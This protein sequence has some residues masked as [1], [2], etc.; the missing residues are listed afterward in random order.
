MRE[1]LRSIQ[2]SY[3]SYASVL[4]VMAAI[5][6]WGHR[7]HWTFLAGHEHAA[8]HQRPAATVPVG[9]PELSA[10][11]A[12]PIAMAAQHLIELP[13]NVTIEDVGI[14]LADVGEQVIYR[15]IFAAGVVNYDQ[16]RT[17]QLTARV[18]GTVWRVEKQVGE[19]VRAGDVLAVIDAMQVGEAKASLLR[20]MSQVDLNRKIVERMRSIGNQAVAI[21]QVQL[22]EAELR[23]SEIDLFNA[24]QSLVNLGLP[25]DVE[26]LAKMND[27]ELL[28]EVK[29]LGLPA[30]LRDKL[31][32]SKLTA[33]LLPIC[34]P[35]DGLVTGRDLALGEIVST[36]RS[37]VEVADVRRMWIFLNVREEDAEQLEVGLPVL[38]TTHGREV[39]T[40]I[41]WISTQVD[42][43]TRTVR[44]RC[45]VDNLIATDK[46]GVLRANLFGMGR[47]R[48]AEVAQALVVPTEA[49]QR[50]GQSHVIFVSHGGRSFE[51]RRVRVGIANETL[52]QVIEGLAVG[53][54]I[55]AAGSHVL[56]AELSR[57]HDANGS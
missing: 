35:F 20:A 26:R 45:D 1:L 29:L 42:E 3:L 15:E 22:A 54:S 9:L 39:E 25:V 16:T 34:A 36:D 56:K 23:K 55:A 13:A 37:H 2:L 31:D 32:A 57:I 8:E 43:R 41:A 7:T 47:I 51:M 50:D 30:S 27:R 6:Y 17:A 11:D 38:F 49:V 4:A 48:V 5:G 24:E 44:V 53:E 40:A 21:K 46:Q 14:Q 19:P 28:A 10:D 18:P 12:S 33:N 52:T